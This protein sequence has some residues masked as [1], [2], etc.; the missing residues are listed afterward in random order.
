MSSSLAKKKTLGRQDRGDR[1]YLVPCPVNA[2]FN[3]SKRILNRNNSC[4]VL[5]K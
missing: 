1:R 3:I 2:I 5:L 4:V